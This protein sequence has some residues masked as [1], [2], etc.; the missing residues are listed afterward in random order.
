[1][2]VSEDAGFSKPERGY[3]DYAFRQLEGAEPESC[4][5]VGDSLLADIGG[6]AAY[7]LDTCWYNPKGQPEGKLRPTYQ[8]WELLE[9]S[10]FL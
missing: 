7:G 10:T 1:M 3:F 6:G 5:I 8:I 4:L 9:L 2:I